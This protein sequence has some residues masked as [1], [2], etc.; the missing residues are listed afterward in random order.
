MQFRSSLGAG[1]KTLIT[2]NDYTLNHNFTGAAVVLSYLGDP[3]A[4][5]Q[6]LDGP[7]LGQAF[8]SVSY[9]RTLHL[10]ES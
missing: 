10:T 9:L 4:P 7:E 3:G 5:N 2:V 8:V 1:L 6:R